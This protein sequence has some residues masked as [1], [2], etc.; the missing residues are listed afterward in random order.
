MPELFPCR[1]QIG[2]SDVGLDADYRDHASDDVPR[3]D[4]EVSAPGVVGRLW[5]PDG[6]A[7]REVLD[8]DV[9][10]FGFR[11]KR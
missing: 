1:A 9:V 11:V 2:S 10:E 3:P 5:S 6:L 7:F 4:L 8:R